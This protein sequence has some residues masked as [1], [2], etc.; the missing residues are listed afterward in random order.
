MH[1]TCPVRIILFDFR[2]L[3]IFN[4]KIC[5]LWGSSFCCFIHPPVPSF[6]DPNI[7]LSMLFSEDFIIDNIIV[8]IIIITA[9]TVTGN[10]NYRNINDSRLMSLWSLYY[11]SPVIE[12]AEGESSLPF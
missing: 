11:V 7:H 1:G 6:L 12:T 10:V 8:V 5:K 3:I 9:T 2:T 4:G